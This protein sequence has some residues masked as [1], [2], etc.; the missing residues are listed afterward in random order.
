MVFDFL[1]LPK[2]APQVVGFIYTAGSYLLSIFLLS[3]L[4]E[5]TTKGY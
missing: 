4:V 5:K 1:R 3:K 2:F